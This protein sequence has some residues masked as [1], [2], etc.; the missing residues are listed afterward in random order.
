MITN[1]VIEKLI[2]YVYLSIIIVCCRMPGF[3]KLAFQVHSEHAT[4]LLHSFNE[5]HQHGSILSDCILS[6]SGA[7][8]PVHRCF[9]AACSP[10][11]HALFTSEMKEKTSSQIK[12]RGI[13]ADTFQPIL[14]FLYSGEISL[15]ENNVT[16]VYPAAKL[17]Q[18]ELLQK[19]CC[20]YFI[21]QLCT[22]NCIGIW[23]YARRYSDTYLEKSAWDYLTVHFTELIDCEEF[24]NLDSSDLS[25]ILS[26]DELELNSEMDSYSAMTTW[27]KHDLSSRKK[28][29]LSLVS[30][31]RFPLLPLSSLNSLL[32]KDIIVTSDRKIKDTLIQAKN[33]QRLRSTKSRQKNT[34]AFQKTNLTPR[35]SK[36]NLSVIGGYS[37]HFVK[38]CESY[39]DTTDHWEINEQLELSPCKHIHWV[40]VIGYRIYTI[41]GDSLTDI[42]LILSKFTPYAWSLLQTSALSKEWEVEAT[43]PSDC[44]S[45][46]FCTMDECIY[47]CGE[48]LL[49]GTLIHGIIRY[50]PG[51]GNLEYLTTLPTPRVSMS[52]LAYSGNLYLIGG[53]DPNTGAIL[54]L[55]E[56]YNLNLNS[57]ESYSNL[58][59]GRYH[60]GAAALDGHIY[61]FGGIGDSEGEINTQLRS[62]DRFSLDSHQWSSI[63]H[64][65]SARAAMAS[66]AWREK[67]YCIGGETAEDVHTRDVFSFSPADEVWVECKP[68]K[69][70]RIHPNVIII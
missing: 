34:H 62:V 69:H 24:S 33:A 9:L 13:E 3:S 46:Q 53:I 56:G 22:S 7:E 44:S 30:C 12:I 20:D 52:F 38:V 14:D 60:L 18:L 19:I 25:V 41:G 45:M 10:Y 61:A 26:S 43:L 63:K 1:C 67:I 54:T 40:G 64:L 2:I 47:G 28:N 51:A 68:L 11:F 66:C 70:S 5:L 65:P 29:I 16:E 6:V 21:N 36:R 8:F 55:F 48:T 37:G 39:D 35:K 4:A 32:S 57:W 27:L 15:N 23:K 58:K 31:I 50:D 59:T 49:D 17:F 42:N